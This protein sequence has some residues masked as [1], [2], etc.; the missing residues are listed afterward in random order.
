M[1]GR[2]LRD[3]R[4]PGGGKV[5]WR[6]KVE[7]EQVRQAADIE[8]LQFLLARFITE[9]ER[10]FLQRLASGDPIAI[11]RNDGGK[12][13]ERARSLHRLGMIAPKPSVVELM[14]SGVSSQLST[15]NEMFDLT[16]GGRKY[17]DLIAT[18]PADFEE[19]WTD[20]PLRPA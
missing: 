1:A 14:H 6:K 2:N 17:L 16:D 20:D 7:A 12:L 4:I 15:L 18:L 9:G 10:D 8:A 13:N 11:E 19:T 3:H 5:E